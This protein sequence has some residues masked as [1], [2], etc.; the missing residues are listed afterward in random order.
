MSDG[1]VVVFDED[2]ILFCQGAT[3]KDALKDARPWIEDACRDQATAECDYIGPSMRISV[4]LS[5]TVRPAT[6]ALMDSIG[7]RGGHADWHENKAGVLD[8]G[9]KPSASEAER[10]QRL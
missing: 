7:V 9:K 10:G 1:F 4:D 3:K 2:D 8:L 6:K 5:W